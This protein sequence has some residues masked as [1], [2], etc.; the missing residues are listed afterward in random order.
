M[1]R[2][3]HLLDSFPARGSDGA[4]YK[5]CAY[6]HLRRDDSVHDGQERWLPT[7]VSEYRLQSGD[8]VAPRS[9]GS[10]VIPASGVTLTRSN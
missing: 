8:P 10:W 6:E 7:G 9:D 1:D 5:V 2:Q 3:F 4:T